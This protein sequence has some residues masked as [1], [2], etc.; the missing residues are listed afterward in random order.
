M[1]GFRG[2]IHFSL[3]GA[4][5]S[6]ADRWVLESPSSAPRPAIA[7]SSA[8]IAAFRRDALAEKGQL[9]HPHELE[10]RIDAT[11][12][13]EILYREAQRLGLG[14]EDTVVHRRLVQNMRFLRDQASWDDAALYRDAVSLGIDESDALVRRRLI[15]RMRLAIKDAA[16]RNEPTAEELQAFLSEH[17]DRFADSE[18]VRISHVFLDP[19][20]RGGT[21]DTDSRRFL[22]DLTRDAIVPEQGAQL[23]DPFLVPAH[24]PLQSERSRCQNQGE[25]AGGPR[26]LDQ[27]L[28]AQA[29][30]QT[31][32]GN[33]AGGAQG[34][35]GG[36]GQ[37]RGQQR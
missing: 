31:H 37:G 5:L 1:Q 3:A 8:Q 11:I 30:D 13:D 33:R 17:P 29:A 36:V 10:A 24:L 22:A 16:R 15:Q 6:A 12:A 19:A 21:T 2:A 26:R 7:I 23:G 20:R 27:P 25:D 14:D 35:R 28:Q 9:P 32:G 18:R 4:V 34:V